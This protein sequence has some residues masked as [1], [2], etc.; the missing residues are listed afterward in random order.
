MYYFAKMG[1]FAKSSFCNNLDKT[2]N[3]YIIIEKYIKGVTHG[4]SI[5]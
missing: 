3:H 2:Q 1:Y 5:G 4:T